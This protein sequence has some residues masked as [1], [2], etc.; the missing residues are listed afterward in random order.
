MSRY[1][2]MAEDETF[3]AQWQGTE[4]ALNEFSQNNQLAITN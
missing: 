4:L 3:L 2:G 1:L